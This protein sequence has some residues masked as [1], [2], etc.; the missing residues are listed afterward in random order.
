[1]PKTV[2]AGSHKHLVRT[3]KDAR[4]RLD[5]TQEELALRLGC[6]RTL[7]TLIETGQRRVDVLEFYAIARALQLDPGELF[8][9]LVAKLP[10]HIE[11]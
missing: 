1:M 10:P 9:E 6:P 2:F 11:I 3:L 5:V 7:I 4:K 8:A